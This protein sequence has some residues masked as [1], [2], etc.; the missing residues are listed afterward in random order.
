MKLA[1]SLESWEACGGDT[2]MSGEKALAE[3]NEQIDAAL[4][5]F[6]SVSE[7]SVTKRL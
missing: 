6:K 1:F 2:N 7:F 5:I 4:E 3:G